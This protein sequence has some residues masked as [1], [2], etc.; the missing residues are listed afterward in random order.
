MK[1]KKTKSGSKKRSRSFDN[2]K[3]PRKSKPKLSKII[4]KIISEND[5]LSLKSTEFG[6]KI[7]NSITGHELK[8]NEANLVKY[9]NSKDY[10]KSK[11]Q[12]Y[13]DSQFK[14]YLP[15]IVEYKK[16]KKKLLCK[17]TKKRL[18]KIPSQIEAHVN[19]KQYK[20]KLIEYKIIQDKKNRKKKADD[21][22]V[23]VRDNKEDF[24]DMNDE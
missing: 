8:A 15:Y 5:F 3:S 18:N 16:N 2:S 23:A 22:D 17:V 6:K 13:D 12:W 14:K 24:I 20:K 7:C 10:K 1:I 4:D 19:G 11:E 9:L 21:E